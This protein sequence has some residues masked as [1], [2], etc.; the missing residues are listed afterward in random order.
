VIDLK[1]FAGF[2]LDVGLVLEFGFEL[3]L[4]GLVFFLF[5]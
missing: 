3:G 2:D 4:G 5:L 1:F